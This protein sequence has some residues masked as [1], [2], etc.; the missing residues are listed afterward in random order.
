MRV[1]YSIELRINGLLIDEVIIDQ[2]YTKKHF[3]VNDW[4]ILELLKNMNHKSSD[5][6]SIQ[7]NY[8]Y[9]VV[10]PVFHNKKPYRVIFLLE[11]DCSYIGV[12]NAFRVQEKK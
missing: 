9:Y 8:S 4:I 10:D 7:G 2:H 1:S 6:K 5:L 11:K 12:I 3:D